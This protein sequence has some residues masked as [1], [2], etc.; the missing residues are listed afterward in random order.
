MAIKGA[1]RW[2]PT[3]YRSSMETTVIDLNP[4]GEQYDEEGDVTGQTGIPEGTLVFIAQAV[5]YDDAAVG[6]TANPYRPGDP[7]T[8]RHVVILHERTYTKSLAAAHA[9]TQA[10][11]DADLAATLAAYRDWILPAGPALVKAYYA[12]RMA[13]P[14]LVE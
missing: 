10:Q 14:V 1:V 2:K 3:M 6:T 4:R 9:A 11:I 7:A 8:E 5:A 13:A 12:A